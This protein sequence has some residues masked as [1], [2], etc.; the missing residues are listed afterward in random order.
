MLRCS[1]QSD[2]PQSTV[3]ALGAAAHTFLFLTPLAHRGS[4]EE[5]LVISYQVQNIILLFNM[6]RSLNPMTAIDPAVPAFLFLFFL[7]T[8][9]VA[10]PLL[11]LPCK[12]QTCRFFKS[13]NGVYQEYGCCSNV[14]GS[15]LESQIDEL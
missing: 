13:E 3:G 2:E 14:G 5:I 4:T 15:H 9:A 8:P 10:S 12:I 11:L 1:A 6:E 7:D